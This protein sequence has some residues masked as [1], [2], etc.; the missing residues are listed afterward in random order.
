MNG[1]RQS[2]LTI[3]QK[4]YIQ[5]NFLKSGE[6]MEDNDLL[7]VRLEKITALK[8]AG[9]DLYPND[10]KPQNTTSDIFSRFGAADGD[11]LAQLTQKFS[12]AG[13]LMA[14]RNFGKAAFIKIQDRKGQIQ[15]YIAKNILSEDAY[16]V[17]KKLDIGDI[18]YISG[19]LFRTKTNELTIEADELH[20]LSKAIRPLPEK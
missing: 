3:R 13:R 17:F 1:S 6:I 19:K 4:K 20:L 2:S 9:I 15:S 10:I 11:A 12:I 14:M 5:T 7:K 8:A 18:I 16:F